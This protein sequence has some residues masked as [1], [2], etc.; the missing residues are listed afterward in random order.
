MNIKYNLRLSQIWHQVI[1]R[2]VRLAIAVALGLSVTAPSALGA[3]KVKLIYGPFNGRIS[4][5][6]LEKYAATGEMT[7]EFRLYAKFVDQETLTQLRLWLNNRF[8]SDRVDMYR[9]TRTPEGEKFLQELGTVIKTHPQRNGFYAIR[10]SLIGAADMPNDS[11]GWTVIEAM[12]NFPT[13]DMQINT[14]DLFKLKKF[15]S[16]NL[17]S[18]QTVGEIFSAQTE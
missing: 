7:R 13:E 1:T 14:K 17:N 5:A 11:D 6:S 8:E 18:N 10:S 4:V 9:F 2:K 3:E 12:Q 15:W 16:E